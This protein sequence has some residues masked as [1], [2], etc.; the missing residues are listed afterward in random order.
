[1][2]RDPDLINNSNSFPDSP[3]FTS[4]LR[5]GHKTW[6]F[7]SKTFPSTT[8]GEFML[9]KFCLLEVWWKPFIWERN[10]NQI[11]MGKVNQDMLVEKKDG[12]N[13]HGML[14][15]DRNEEVCMGFRS[16]KIFLLR[17]CGCLNSVYWMSGRRLSRELNLN[18][19]YMWKVKP[20]AV[21]RA[22]F[23]SHT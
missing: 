19:I 2:G 21:V 12:R 15:I 9:Q 7:G 23:G 18:Q 22:V 17:L 14:T 11:Y 4:D 16:V 3:F 10:L 20:E 1:M 13:W 8:L 5:K 6:F